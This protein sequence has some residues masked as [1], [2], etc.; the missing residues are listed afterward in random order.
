M[1]GNVPSPSHMKMC[2]FNV[3][4]LDSPAGYIHSPNSMWHRKSLEYGHCMRY[5]VAGVENDTCCPTRRIP[6]KEICERVVE[7]LAA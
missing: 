6:S 2:D 3:D 7:N 5:T 4:A 1:I